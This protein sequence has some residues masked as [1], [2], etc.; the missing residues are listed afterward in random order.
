[1]KRN[2]LLVAGLLL[3]MILRSQPPYPPAPAPPGNM[4]QLEYFFNTDPGF[5]NGT[6]F[7]LP[8]PQTDV[9][10]FALSIPTTGFPQGFY[11]L[12]LRSRDANGQWSHIMDAS[13]SNVV[14]PVYPTAPPAAVNIVK[15]EYVIDANLPFGSGTDI[16]I[17]PGLNIANLNVS[18]NTSTVPAGPHILYI[19]SQDA[20][21]VW[22]LT[23]VSFFDNSVAP[24]YPVAPAAAGNIQQLEYFIDTDPGFGLA[25]PITYTPA[26]DVTVSFPVNGLSAGNHVFYIRSRQN[27][28]GLVTAQPFSVISTLPV[29]WLYVQGQLQT[30]GALIKWATGSESNA[31]RFEIEHST[32][33]TAYTKI[34][35]TPA[36]GNSTVTSRY[37]FIHP[38]PV[39]GKN[40]Y[41]IK[42]IDLDGRFTYSAVVVLYNISAKTVI[43]TPNPVQHSTTIYF[44]DASAKTIRLLK[45]NGQLVLT[46]LVQ[47][48]SSS[49]LLDMNNLPA[50]LYMLQ[51]QTGNETE[52]FKIIKQ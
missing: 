46:Q 40:F 47:P 22:S 5:G 1:M 9:N 16:P 45:A 35:A 19:R 3:T 43:I 13:F 39:T 41:R 17:T 27:P 26:T 12:Y 18:I 50:G 33:G 11:R 8:A 6:I 23:G 2:L 28:W 37:E 15:L 24:P 14:A 20:N 49:Q 21:G 25:T 48:G 29:T 4:V 34:G 7:T 32:N 38:S 52:V 44:K 30:N 51:V 36:A 42:Q 10:N 31:A